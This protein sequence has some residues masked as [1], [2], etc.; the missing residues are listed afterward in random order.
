MKHLNPLS[1]KPLLAVTCCLL[2]SVISLSAIAFPVE[3]ALCRNLDGREICIVKIKRSAK[4]HY[5][6]R[7]VVSIDGQ[8]EPLVIYDCRD[9]T[10]SRKNKYPIPFK[11]NSA[12]ELV[13]SLFD[14]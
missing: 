6:Y 4:Y 1:N 13:C 7:T 2:F 5:R 10:I 8:K 11:S 9:R 14:K 3:A 12:G